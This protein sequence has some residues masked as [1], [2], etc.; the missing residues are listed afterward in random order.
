MQVGDRMVLPRSK[1]FQGDIQWE[2]VAV[3]PP[4]VRVQEVIP[5]RRQI[6]QVAD[7]ITVQRANNPR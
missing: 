2:K 6:P 4:A 5:A 7:G 3:N 1:I